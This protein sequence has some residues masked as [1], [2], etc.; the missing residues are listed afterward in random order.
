MDTRAGASLSLTGKTV[1]AL[2]F[3]APILKLVPGLSESVESLSPTFNDSLNDSFVPAKAPKPVDVPLNAPN[4]PVVG[5]LAGVGDPDETMGK[6]ERE[7]PSAE[8]DPNA[9]DA[10]VD[11]A[12]TELSELARAVGTPEA[13]GLFAFV[14]ALKK[15]DDE[16]FL[17]LPK[18]P[19]PV[20]GLNTEDV[21]T[22]FAKAPDVGAATAP[23]CDEAGVVDD[24]GG[25]SS[26]D[27][28]SS[29]KT[30]EAFPSRGVASGD[31][32]GDP[33]SFADILIGD[34]AENTSSFSDGD[35]ARSPDGD[36]P[37]PEVPDADPAPETPFP[38]DANGELWFGGD[39]AAAKLLLAGG[40]GDEAAAVPN[41]DAEELAKALNP[42]E[43]G[44]LN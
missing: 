3:S 23:K 22:R 33:S 39:A 10:E 27:L 44:V 13:A 42:P 25:L 32:S 17:S 15:G 16:G 24:L 11:G 6:T 9:G 7:A 34:L 18:A 12:P 29:E 36:P 37:N 38:V 40:G 43:L 21:V 4:P 8:A 35:F 28:S 41:G 20:A 14:F 1:T 26:S 2:G 30:M 19:K 31:D 5:I